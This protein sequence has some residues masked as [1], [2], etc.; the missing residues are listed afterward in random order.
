MTV[1]P[2]VK[3]NLGLSVLRK[4]EDG[5]HDIDTVF[6][7]CMEICDTL[8]VITGDDYSRTS[9]SLFARYGEDVTQGISE[10]GKLMI[11]IARDGGIDWDPLSDLCAKAFFIL[12]EDFDLPPVK[13][14]LEKKAPVGAGL[15]GGSSDAAFTL[16]CLN[17]LA[18]LGLFEDRLASYA[19][20][21]GSDCAFFIY[22]RPMRGTGRGEILEDISLD[23][24]GYDL[25]VIVPEGISV[26]TKEAYG[27]IVPR[28]NPAFALPEN[29][30]DVPLTE[31]LRHPV[32]DWKHLVYNDFETT[33]FNRHPQLAAIKQSLYESG[34][35]YASMSG[36][37]SALFGI[38]ER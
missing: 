13:V 17:G 23:L 2:N 35:L 8:E 18:G 21:L 15:G 20:R 5:F 10:D 37:G 28:E 6:V 19:A 16:K 4:R 24:G 3:V 14:F 26:S 36:S 33:V 30:E 31:A 22:N 27:G 11:T 32:K 38:Y 12:A 7:P 9:A 25:K 29:M 1:H 34:A